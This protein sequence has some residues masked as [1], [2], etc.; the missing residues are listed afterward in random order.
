M[1]MVSHFR[2]L[3]DATAAFRPKYR[4]SFHLFLVALLN[5][6]MAIPV[7]AS[8]VAP[9][10]PATVF[11][12]PVIFSL[13]L[14]IP[15]TLCAGSSYFVTVLVHAVYQIPMGGTTVVAS[16][17]V[18]PG[19]VVNA[20]SDS[21]GVATISPQRSVSSIASVGNLIGAVSFTLHAIKAGDA[22][23]TFHG[24]IPAQITQGSPGP[25]DNAWALRVD[26]CAYRVS[27]NGSWSKAFPNLRTTLTDSLSGQITR[28][29][30]S[31]MLRGTANVTWSLRSFSQMCSHSHSLTL[32]Q[33][34]MYGTPDA[35]RLGVGIYANAVGF[36]TVNCGSSNSGQFNAP[37]I[38]GVGASTGFTAGKPS[39]VQVGDFGL[40]GRWTMSVTPIKAH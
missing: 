35:E 10:P 29:A 26:N 14:R 4:R 6:A 23:V 1:K 37:V 36:S 15:G 13:D 25:M 40:A 11:N 17:V 27:E 39:T 8:T 31:G 34:D 32:D 28:D 12:V 5:L 21:P 18:V 7:T 3:L 2:K 33:A 19:I 30:T 38:F 9:A 16:D 22:S 20:S 24:D